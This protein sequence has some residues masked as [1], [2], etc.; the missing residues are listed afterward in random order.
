MFR[1]QLRSAILRSP[2][3]WEETCSSINC[4]NMVQSV[5]TQHIFQQTI[6]RK[7]LP[8]LENKEEK[9]FF[10]W[11]ISWIALP[12]SKS[13]NDD[14]KIIAASKFHAIVICWE[15]PCT[16]C[17]KQKYVCYIIIQSFRRWTQQPLQQHNA[18]SI[19]KHLAYHIAVVVLVFLAPTSKRVVLQNPQPFTRHP[20]CLWS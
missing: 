5:K 12:E 17:I 14:K 6:C 3:G 18:S 11:I 19:F 15:K 13:K 1:W 2:S 4:L 20:R 8:S 7:Q 9:T 16:V 10:G